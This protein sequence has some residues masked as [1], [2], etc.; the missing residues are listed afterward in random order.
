MAG[1]GIIP[2]SSLRAEGKAD[3]QTAYDARLREAPE[4]TPCPAPGEAART[5]LHGIK[6]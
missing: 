3:G 5:S 2:G 4:N 6:S 1:A